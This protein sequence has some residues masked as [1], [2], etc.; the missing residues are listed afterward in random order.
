MQ[1]SVFLSPWAISLRPLYLRTFNPLP[2]V[3]SR[4][5]R[6]FVS[7]SLETTWFRYNLQEYVLHNTVETVR[8]LSPIQSSLALGA[9]MLHGCYVF[10]LS[11]SLIN[12]IP[13]VIRW[14]D[15]ISNAPDEATGM[16]I[17]KPSITAARQPKIAVIHVESIFQSMHLIP[18]VIRKILKRL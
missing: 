3:N 8:S 5:Q 10:F 4:T 9:W 18:V 7:T 12:C 15:H 2:L 14:F 11:A 17:V 1:F 13:V 6:L 16:W